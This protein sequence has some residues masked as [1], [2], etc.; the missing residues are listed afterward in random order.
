MRVLI[1]KSDT[2]DDDFWIESMISTSSGYDKERIQIS[3][4]QDNYSISLS[5]PAIEPKHTIS[6]LHSKQSKRAANG[7]CVKIDVLVHIPPSKPLT[8]LSI[9]LDYGDT[10]ILESAWGSLPFL[11]VRSGH[12]S[13]TAQAG[14]RLHVESVEVALGQ[15]EMKGSILITKDMKMRSGR[16]DVDIDIGFSPFGKSARLDISTGLGDV[17][18]LVRDEMYRDIHAVY[19]S[20]KGDIRLLYPPTYEGTI[21]L[22]SELGKVDVKGAAVET[23][24]RSR[25]GVLPAYFE[26]R[27]GPR[28]FLASTLANASIGNV[29]AEYVDP[30]ERSP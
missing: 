7:G 13:F 30:T 18:V 5:S 21:K 3:Y 14:Q 23:Q 25:K 17:D 28:D 26:G 9:D 29:H 27:Q 1:D 15:G 6:P 22:Y 8:G 19:T 10:A 2:H 16:G 24:A 20:K 12:G 4:A 11:H